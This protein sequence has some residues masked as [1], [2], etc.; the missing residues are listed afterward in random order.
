[1]ETSSDSIRSGRRKAILNAFEAID[2]TSPS[3]SERA[4]YIYEQL[5]AL[6]PKPTHWD[7][8]C[9]CAETLGMLTLELSQVNTRV[10]EI[11]R[12][13]YEI[14]YFGGDENPSC[15][16]PQQNQKSTTLPSNPSLTSSD[17]TGQSLSSDLVIE[18]S[19]SVAL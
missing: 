12:M 11:T 14:H 13:I 6:D 8:V 3:P 19:Q 17:Q 15:L 4:K 7:L 18:K 2:K 1:M 9:F 10:A 5:N 16:Q